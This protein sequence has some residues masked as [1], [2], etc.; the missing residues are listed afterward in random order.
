VVFILTHVWVNIKTKAAGPQLDLNWKVWG[1]LRFG[2][3]TCSKLRT[4]SL[5]TLVWVGKENSREGTRV[6]IIKTN[7][8]RNSFGLVAARTKYG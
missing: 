4:F 8:C 7:L 5:P 2:Y 1:G 3:E 6:I